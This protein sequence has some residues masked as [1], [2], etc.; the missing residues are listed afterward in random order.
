MTWVRLD[1]GY[2]DHPKVDRVGPLAAWLNVCAWA[3]CARNLTD[4]FVPIERVPR[5]AN[6][7]STAK[8]AAALVE[9]NLWEP[10]E[11]G[12]MVHD[13]LA[14]NPSREAVL[15]ERSAT[16][17]RVAEWRDKHGS[18]G[19]TPPDTNGGGN[20]V[21]NPSS[22][23]VSNAVS[24]PPPVPIPVPSTSPKTIDDT[25]SLRSGGTAP[26][27]AGA[28]AVKRKRGPPGNPRVAAVVDAFQALGPPEP[29]MTDR[30]R[31][32]IKCSNA[33]PEL[34]AECYDA[35]R[36]GDWGDQW[37]RDN[38]SVHA[39]VDWT[40]AYREQRPEPT[41]AEHDGAPPAQLGPDETRCVQ[42]G[43]GGSGAWCRDC[44]EQARAQRRKGA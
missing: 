19:V 16:A 18:N 29:L 28:A 9:V 24:T 2:P 23:G 21:S 37:K 44:R 38:L 3:Y 35:V 14:Y 13:Y 20:S 4:G 26:Q 15:R 42:C 41:A 25:P 36:R 32:A 27:A 30:D 1:D 39:A 40:N 43:V 11:G 7:G 12:Y 34:I 31:A 10:V 8:L 22:N 5:L 33:P 6:V 17:K